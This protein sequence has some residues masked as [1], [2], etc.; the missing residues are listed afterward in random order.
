[1][2]KG[3]SETNEE[4]FNLLEEEKP[5]VQDDT[6]K[7]KQSDVYNL[8]GTLKLN[9]VIKKTKNGKANLQMFF[10]CFR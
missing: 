4:G 10:H 1:M 9:Y 5:Q 3:K 8:L 7:G 2:S 6:T